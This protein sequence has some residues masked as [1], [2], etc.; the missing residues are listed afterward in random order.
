MHSMG[1]E[2]TKT[3]P[4]SPWQNGIAERWVGSLRREL[5]DHVVPFST[6]HL[7]SLVGEYVRYYN[8]DR[9]HLGLD[10]DAPIP[11]ANDPGPPP[12]EVVALPRVGGLHHRYTRA[13]AR[14]A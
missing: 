9:C 3:Q 14:A 13:P 7:R 2:V 6:K 10:K 1:I 5:L 4:R 12:G 8:E 11:R